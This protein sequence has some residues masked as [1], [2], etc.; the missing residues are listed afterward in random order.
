M[1]FTANDQAWIGLKNLNL[2]SCLNDTC[3][4]QLTWTDGTNF[5]Y[6]NLPQVDITVTMTGANECVHFD[7]VEN[8]LKD[9]LSC[10][11]TLEYFCSWHC[12]SKYF[13]K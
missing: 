13:L 2:I 7:V 4:N 1:T 9:S 12:S 8:A 6:P 3:D 10:T 11:H 5:E